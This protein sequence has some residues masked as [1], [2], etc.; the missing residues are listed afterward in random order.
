[1]LGVDEGMLFSLSFACCVI[2]G[3]GR[4]DDQV[5]L[6]VY[7]C[8]YIYTGPSARL[9]IYIYIYIYTIASRLM[10]NEGAQKTGF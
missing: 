3:G 1:M 4:G 8:E 9:Y 6:C 10:K 5:R 7:V 2:I